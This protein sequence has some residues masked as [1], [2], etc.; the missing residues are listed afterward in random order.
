MRYEDDDISSPLVAE[1]LR[2]GGLSLLIYYSVYRTEALATIWREDSEID[3]SDLMLHEAYHAMRTVT[4]GKVRTNRATI[5]YFSQ[6]GTSTSSDPMRDWVGHLLRSRFST[7][8]AEMVARIAAAA[9]AAG[10]DAAAAA[11]QARGH[12]ESYFR[13]FLWSSYGVVAEIKRH[14][15]KASPAAVKYWQSRPSFSVK[16]Q[17]A[18]VLAKLATAGASEQDLS[19]TRA[20]ISGI[21]SAL[22]PQAFTA[23]AGPFLAAARAGGSGRAWV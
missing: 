5:T 20:E 21:E 11:E 18:S 1:R 15:R 10:A 23:F 19:R 22:S 6:I 2:Q 3:F 16:G 4:L 7:D 8:S 17:L 9:A 14:M 12:I 13:D